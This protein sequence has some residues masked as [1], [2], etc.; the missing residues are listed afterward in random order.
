MAKGGSFEREISSILSKWWTGGARDDIFYR[1]SSS[2]GRFTARYKRGKQTADHHGDICSIDVCG[3]PLTDTFSIELKTGYSGR[4][5]EKTGKVSIINWCV[6][7]ILDSRQTLPVL[8][9]MW[10]QSSRDASRSEKLP[11]LIF[12]RPLLSPN[13]T[14]EE[15]VFLSL[16]AHFDNVPEKRIAIHTADYSLVVFSLK[17]FF[18]WVNGE[19][20]CCLL[21]E[22]NIVF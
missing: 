5:K 3:K 11:L 22:K 2:G 21:T 12:R 14:M 13:I 16:G 15:R 4:R 6:L 10:E 1:S 9:K 7:D 8:L 17:D 19:V 20:F 18:T